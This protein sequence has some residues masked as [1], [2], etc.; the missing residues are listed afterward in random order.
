MAH[1]GMKYPVVSNM[2]ETNM[3][4]DLFLQKQLTSGTPNKNDADLWADDGIAETDKIREGHGHFS[5]WMI[6]LWKTR[7]NCLVIHM[8]RQQLE[9][10]WEETPESIEDWNRR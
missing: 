3:Q 5:W 8:L 1:I 7:Q 4:M 9:F 6:C 10:W 2:T